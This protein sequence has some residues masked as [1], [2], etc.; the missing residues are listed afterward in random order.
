WTGS[1][2]KNDFFGFSIT[3]PESW[4]IFGKEKMKTL[5]QEGMKK[6]QDANLVNEIE[7]KKMAKSAEIT[8]ASLFLVIRYLNEEVIEK[9]VSN[10]SITLGAENLSLPGKKIDRAKYVDLFRQ[11]LAKAMPGA[12]IKTETSKMLGG[13][14][15]TSLNIEYE[16][17]GIHIYE[18]YLICLK[19]DFAVLFSLT[20]TD[21]SDKK[22]LDAVMETLAWK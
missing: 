5:I 9:K 1:T 11:N 12:V 2:Y 21:D 19:N 16:R 8:S 22:Q 20:W 4:H 3:V 18:E 7:M 10:S 15:F 13:R 17:H 6:T 14:E